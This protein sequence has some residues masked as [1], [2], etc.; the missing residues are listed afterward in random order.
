M[1]NFVHA[2]RALAVMACL[3]LAGCAGVPFGTSATPYPR[4]VAEHHR[5][6][7]FDS[8][9][10]LALD[11]Y[12]PVQAA[13]APVVVF[14]HG[15]SWMRGERGRYRF[16]GR[17]LAAHGIVTVIPDYRKIPA[18]PF[19]AQM[20][21]AAHAVAWA[22]AHAAEF[23]GDAGD[24]FVM[25]HSSGGHIAALLATDPRRLAREGLRPRDLAG[26]I[27]LAGVYVFLARDAADPEMLAVFGHTP[28]TQRNVEPVWFVHGAEPPMLL[29]QGVADTEV[30]SA[31]SRALEEAVGSM[32]EEADLKL[33]P[34]VGHGG[35]LLAITWPLNVDTPVLNDILAF[36]R[37]HPHAI[38]ANP[39]ADAP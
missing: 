2:L 22:H 39:S 7:V 25:G 33:Y 6:I 15:G 9:H 14:F 35:L 20:Q 11:V 5:G 10:A 36:I 13:H 31:N 30:N 4:V 29:L 32:H 23:G 24:L 34:G 18:A 17:A 37:A 19:D 1:K 27:G 3:P 28:E 8:V 38:D 21:D 26:F 12:R 16:V